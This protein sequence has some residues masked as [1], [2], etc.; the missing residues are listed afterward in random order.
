MVTT[1]CFLVLPLFLCTS[2]RRIDY[3]ENSFS[4]LNQAPSLKTYFL[5]LALLA[6]A[7]ATPLPSPREITV[8]DN[9]FN[10]DNDQLLCS[11]ISWADIAAFYLGNYVAHAATIYT[12][13]GEATFSIARSILSSL[14]FPTAGIT[15]GLNAI[16]RHA[17][18]NESASWNESD[19]EVA[20]RAGALCMVIRSRHWKEESPSQEKHASGSKGEGSNHVN[21]ASK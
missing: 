13:P 12:Y 1:Y 19:L 6:T 14:F 21:N 9:T 5:F 7:Y 17:H 16:F 15:R 20:A 8:P 11:P 18:W 4:V 3:F 10:H 2:L